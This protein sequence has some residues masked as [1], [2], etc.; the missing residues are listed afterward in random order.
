MLIHG[1]KESIRSQSQ[2]ARVQSSGEWARVQSPIAA[3]VIG[4]PVPLMYVL[5]MVFCEDDIVAW[6]VN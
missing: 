1:S 5:G 2:E 3:I 4:Q 6:V